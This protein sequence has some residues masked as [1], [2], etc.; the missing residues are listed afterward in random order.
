[1]REFD[2]FQAAYYNQ[3]RGFA[4]M[5]K[6]SIPLIAIMLQRATRHMLDTPYY[7]GSLIALRHRQTW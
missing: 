2:G 4:V 5:F 7:Y 1:M 3:C 6:F